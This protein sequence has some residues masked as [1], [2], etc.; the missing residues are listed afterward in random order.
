MWVA[1]KIWKAYRYIKADSSLFLENL[2]PCLSID[3]FL[4]F[5]YIDL[6]MISIYDI[7]W[8]ELNYQI[9]IVKFDSLSSFNFS[10]VWPCSRLTARTVWFS[11]IY[12][13]FLT[14]LPEDQSNKLWSSDPQSTNQLLNLYQ[15]IVRFQLAFLQFY[16]PNFDSFGFLYLAVWPITNYSV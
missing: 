5:I 7:A 9:L 4:T 14:N 15:N 2:A 13:W 1:R 12:G 8:Y 6:F 10:V 11:M 16:L 3:H